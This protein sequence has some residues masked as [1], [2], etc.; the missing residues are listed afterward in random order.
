MPPGG[1]RLLTGARALLTHSQGIV[2]RITEVKPML[3]VATYS[4]EQCG[5][6]TF[7]EVRPVLRQRANA[8]PQGADDAGRPLM[9]HRSCRGRSRR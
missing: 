6:E 7:Q 1:L 8:R 3:V 9:P 2:T 5:F 4:C